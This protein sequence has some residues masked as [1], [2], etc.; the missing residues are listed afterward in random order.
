MHSPSS[1]DPSDRIACLLTRL[2]TLDGLGT[3]SWDLIQAQLNELMSFTNSPSGFVGDILDLASR[4]VHLH[5]MGPLNWP[6]NPRQGPSTLWDE[7]IRTG[8]PVVIAPT[9][10][11]VPDMHGFLGLPLL[12]GGV[13]IG[14]LGLA[15][16]PEGYSEA[17]AQALA[18]AQALIAS[19]LA[20]WKTEARLRDA[21]V[22]IDAQYRQLFDA[23]GVGITRISLSGRFLD[24]NERFTEI[25]GRTRDQLLQ[26]NR[27]D[28]THP[29][30]LATDA[31]LG[32]SVLDGQRSRYSLE[33]RYLRPDGQVVWVMLSVAL[34]RD[35]QGQPL[36]F[37]AVSEDIT[38]RRQ[39]EEAMNSAK[40]AERA[41]KA[42]TDFLS[43]MSHE[44]RT[45]LN[46]M[47]GFAQL[48]RVDPTNPIN[49]TQRKKVGHIERAGAHLLAMLTDVLDL[50]RIEAGG[51]PL[52][53]APLRL[54]TLLEEVM[55]L[56][57]N[58]VTQNVQVVMSP[59]CED[60]F[61]K[62]DQV[63]LRQILLNLITNAVKYNKPG[64]RVMVEAQGV[65]SYVVITVSDTGRG[66]SEEQQAH[67]FEPFNRLGAERTSVEGTGIGL[68][69]VKRLIDLMRGRIEISSQ[70]GIGSSFRVWLPAALDPHLPVPESGLGRLGPR[71]GWGAFDALNPG[72]LTLLYAEDNVVNVELVRQV[73]HMRPQWHLEV[74]RCGAEALEMVR[75]APPD[76]LLLDMHLGDMSGLDVSDAL[77]QQADTAGIP[78]V[79]LSA[80]A[81]PDQIAAAR[82]RGFVDYLTKPL[83]VARLLALLDC[84]AEQLLG[85]QNGQ[86]ASDG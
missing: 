57:S 39:F 12:R 85:A 28:F 75:A 79:A 35:D 10:S 81:M 23:A 83:D 27:H 5:S 72:T 59:P 40:A 11:Q 25:T 64:G 68:V 38:Q 33:K 62:A 48:L 44:L 65:R 36:H 41:N 55:A 71:S 17:F 47:L 70:V 46:A 67:L 20:A 74:A 26:L 73:M 56:V 31:A 6:K 45:P 2:A 1:L 60:L 52:N 54:S 8:A 4:Q 66:L 21:Q 63:R 42:K 7:V 53:L 19:N 37:V 32:A 61:V 69:I 86:D 24:A 51:L 16:R 3:S 84:C 50:S 82:E 29:D 34:L 43:R 78:R 30:D 13:L 9:L 76:L 18:P 77:A 14:V 15:N 80:D 49:D 58:Q 22:A